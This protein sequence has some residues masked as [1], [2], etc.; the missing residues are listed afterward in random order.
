MESSK[1]PQDGRARKPWATPRVITSEV[2]RETASAKLHRSPET[3]H[4][5]TYTS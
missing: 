4:S 3:V 1:E 2:T 5:T